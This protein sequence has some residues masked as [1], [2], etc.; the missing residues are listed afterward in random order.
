MT[1]TTLHDLAVNVGVTARP[2]RKLPFSPRTALAVGIAVLAAGAGAAYLAAPKAE[3]A[4]DAAYL[5]ADSSTIA[6]KVKGLVAEVLVRDNQP[7][8]RGDPLIRIDPEE[9]DAHVAAASADLQKAQAAVLAS[10]AALTSLTAEEALAAATTR[11]AQTSIRAAD[12]QS[13]QA[14]GDQARYDALAEK[15]F[16]S[17]HDADQFKAA[18]ITAASAADHSR[19]ELDVSRNQ[20]S[21]TE[22]KRASLNAA[23][24][25]AQ[26]AAASAQA[27]LD[28][29]KQDQAHT[30]ITSPIDGVVGDRQ[31]QAGDYVQPGSRLLSIVPMSSLYVTADFK[32]TQVSRMVAGQAATI[33]V[34]ALPG[35]ALKG[36]VESF[37]PGSGSQFSLLPFEP[38]TGNFTKIVQRV[39]V[40]IRIDPGQA[41]LERLRP[42]LSTTVTVR[43]ANV[44]AAR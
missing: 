19:A 10:Q 11:S 38:G 25:Q 6:P 5:Q 28:L 40:R 13:E 32:E 34:D 9:F 44:Q 27:A 33:R 3:V 14:K 16:V 23:L 4:T 41:G 37:A 15:G 24:A 1:A 39:P 30:L 20:A 2:A 36:E 21:V 17:R 43:L 42:G 8:K 31:A 18:A 12:A 29:A 22:A 35:R 7:V 26:A